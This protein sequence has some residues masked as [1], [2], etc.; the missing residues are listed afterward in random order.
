MDSPQPKEEGIITSATAYEGE[1]LEAEARGEDQLCTALECKSI[2]TPTDTDTQK[3]QDQPPDSAHSSLAQSLP[4]D[5]LESILSY[6]SV[7]P[8]LVRN[9]LNPE[10]WETILHVPATDIL[11]AFAKLSLTSWTER[12]RETFSRG[13]LQLERIPSRLFATII[14]AYDALERVTNEDLIK[15]TF[16]GQKPTAMSEHEK[17][18]QARLLFLFESY[19]PS[20]VCMIGNHKMSYEG[21]VQY[22]DD[23][24][25][26][27]VDILVQFKNHSPLPAR[28]ILEKYTPHDGKIISNSSIY[29]RLGTDTCP[30]HTWTR[31]EVKK[32]HIDR[33]APDSEFTN[34]GQYGAL[35]MS[36]ANT[37]YR[38]LLHSHVSELSPGIPDDEI[39][40]RVRLLNEVDL[41]M[42]GTSPTAAIPRSHSWFDEP[43][44]TYASMLLQTGEPHAVPLAALIMEARVPIV[45]LPKI[46]CQYYTTETTDDVEDPAVESRITESMWGKTPEARSRLLY[47]SAN[48]YVAW[49]TKN[50]LNGDHSAWPALPRYVVQLLGDRCKAEEGKKNFGYDATFVYHFNMNWEDFLKVVDG[51]PFYAPAYPAPDGKTLF[52]LPFLGTALANIHLDTVNTMKQITLNA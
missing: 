38:N 8:I 5:V 28:S 6:A 39:S 45:Q 35:V 52:F 42:L 9:L 2:L 18:K 23:R 47:L 19:E 29:A 27:K 22:I 14:I 40:E 20:V 51:M 44:R 24:W 36:I 4:P 37:F 17:L 46:L 13:D 33:F 7:N 41:S 3:E 48:N 1:D 15:Y 31:D 43:L 25:R 34:F 30:V 12:F 10:F 50:N 21:A 26:R 32:L 16:Y 49:V 11:K